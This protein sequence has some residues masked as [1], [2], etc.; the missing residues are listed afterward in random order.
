LKGISSLGQFFLPRIRIFT[1]V[2][3]LSPLFH[4]YNIEILLKIRELGSTNDTKEPLKGFY[5]WPA[6]MAL[7]RRWCILISVC[8][9]D[10]LAC[11][12]DQFECENT[13]LCIFGSWVC[14]GWDDCGDMSD[15]RNCSK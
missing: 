2:S 5:T 15:E 13:G 10:C 4:T 3:Y 11:T 6:G 9:L 7:P 1:I 12:D 8:L 14:D